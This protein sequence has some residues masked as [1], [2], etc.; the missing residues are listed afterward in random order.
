MNVNQKSLSDVGCSAA[1]T[2]IMDV[3]YVAINLLY[4]CCLILA[5]H[6]RH[7]R[8]ISVLEQLESA[9]FLLGM[10]LVPV[11]SSALSKV[12]GSICV[13]CVCYLCCLSLRRPEVADPVQFLSAC[14]ILGIT[15][16]VH[17]CCRLFT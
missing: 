10:T 12:I 14:Y 8:V 16:L 5:R 2:Y 9:I 15:I 6:L 17:S 13:I 7:V 4:R 1:Y 3:K 11:M